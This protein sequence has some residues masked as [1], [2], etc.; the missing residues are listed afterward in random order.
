[1]L[2][3]EK[4]A[5][6]IFFIGSLVAC[7]QYLLAQSPE[8]TY[9]RSNYGC[10]FSRDPLYIVNPTY[11]V[12][13]DCNKR[14]IIHP[15]MGSF[16]ITLFAYAREFAT[17]KNG[18]Y[19]KGKL[20]TADTVGLRVLCNADGHIFWKTKFKVFDNEQV[21]QGADAATFDAVMCFNI[22]YLIDKNFV[23]Y[24]GKKIRRADP[25]SFTR[26]CSEPFYDKN[27]I[28]KGD[29]LLKYQGKILRSVNLV[30]GKTDN[31]VIYLQR[32]KPI[33]SVDARSLI[34]LSP[35]YSADRH[36]VYFDTTAFLATPEDISQFKVWEQVNSRFFSD[37]KHLYD[38]GGLCADEIDVKTFS[39][40]PKSDIF[41]DK[42]GIYYIIRNGTKKVS[43]MTLKNI[44]SLIMSR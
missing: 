4:I 26:T 16:R 29:S 20:V 18:V 7:Q 25:A 28:Y 22:P 5:L 31:E 3:P 8:T 43:E 6:I 39:M 33:K 19:L 21:M 36:H 42:N 44:R 27:Y 34:G 40:L 23:Y 9:P 15:D 13:Q 38:N 12:Y 1:M 32:N 37:G 14:E 17:D 41:Y 10:K 11:A 30:F 35:S 24:L 2:R